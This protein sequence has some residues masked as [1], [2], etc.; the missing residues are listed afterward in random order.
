M[1]GVRGLAETPCTDGQLQLLSASGM[2]GLWR[3]LAMHF[4]ACTCWGPV[5]GKMFANN[6]GVLPTPP[7]SFQSKFTLMG[8]KP[9]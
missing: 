1:T 5:G 7:T 6:V 4:V 3:L 9:N 2:E 8:L